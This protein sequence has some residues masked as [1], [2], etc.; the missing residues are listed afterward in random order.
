MFMTRVKLVLQ[1]DRILDNITCTCNKLETFRRCGGRQV[2]GGWVW[3][4]REMFIRA[5][6]SIVTRYDVK[7]GLITARHV[8]STFLNM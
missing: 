3:W 8:C 1:A 7:C 2:G 5:P 6:V 4:E